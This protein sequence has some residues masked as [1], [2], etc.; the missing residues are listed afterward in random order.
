[1]AKEGSIGLPGKNTWKIKDR[2]LLGW[3]IED[4]KKSKLVDKV[5]VSTNGADVA[6]VSKAS[7]AEVIMREDELAKNEKFMQAVE[8]AIGYIKGQ[9]ADLKII[10]IPQCVVPFRDPD[11]FDRCIG[12][13]LKNPDYDSAVT[14][15]QVGFIPEALMKMEKDQLVP[16]FP[17]TQKYVSGS[18]QDSCGFEIDHT[19]ECFTYNS[20]LKRAEGIKPWSYLGKRIMGIKQTYHN[21]NCFVDVHTMDDIHWLKMIVDQLGF[22]GMRR[23]D[24]EGKH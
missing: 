19:V 18:R 14:I 2:T 12:F 23:T 7:G 10:A 6:K 11:I 1:M 15:R 16:Y 22:D 3:T 9:H 17:E 24:Q 5:F 4:A 20:F 21:H 13:L 8:H